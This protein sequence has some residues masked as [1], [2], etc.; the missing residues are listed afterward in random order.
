MN[1]ISG[2]PFPDAEPLFD[3]REYLVNGWVASGAAT[4]AI[5]P[6]RNTL[7]IVMRVRG[8][9]ASSRIVAEGLPFEPPYAVRFQGLHGNDSVWISMGNTGTLLLTA[10]TAPFPGEITS[11][12]TLPRR[13][14]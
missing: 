6:G 2:L 12:Q 9:N 11:I 3:M 10:G 14:R 4:F 13:V 1:P 5:Q 8:D 7:L